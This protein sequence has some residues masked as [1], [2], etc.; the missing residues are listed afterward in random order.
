M[1]T[2][3]TPR[4]LTP[5]DL[6]RLPDE[7]QGFELV[8]GELRELNVSKESSRI[9]GLIYFLLESHVRAS[10]PAW[11][12]PE[13]TSYSCFPDEPGK[14]RRADTSV[15]SLDRMPPAS[16]EDEGHCT[17]VPDLVAEVISPN[18]LAKDVEEKRDEWLGAGVKVVW[19][20]SPA[21]RT[22]HV[23]RADGS[24]VLLRETDIL[25]AEG[26]LPGFQCSVA[27]LFRLPGEPATTS[28]AS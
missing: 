12:F 5:D 19:I 15:I 25:T 16:Y 2:I 23:H 13:G 3:A 11:V 24:T 14:V 26:V 17:I 28:Q 9:A 8:N 22:V 10:H 1:S 21:R 4:V 18:D 6:L 27:N 7:G 20:V